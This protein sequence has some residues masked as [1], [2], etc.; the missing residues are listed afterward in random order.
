MC[1]GISSKLSG[2]Q[3]ALMELTSPE[4]LRRLRAGELDFGL[5]RRSQFCRIGMAVC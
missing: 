2:V 1:C 4:Q 3:L 5:L